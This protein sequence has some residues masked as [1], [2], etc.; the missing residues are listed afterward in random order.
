MEMIRRPGETTHP[1]PSLT[2]PVPPHLLST[3]YMAGAQDKQ[4][5]D[6]PRT[7]G[8]TQISGLVTCILQRGREDSSPPRPKKCINKQMKGNSPALVTLH[9]LSSH[10]W[11]V[12]AKT[13]N[14]LI[15]PGGPTGRHLLPRSHLIPS[16]GLAQ[17]SVKVFPG[18]LREQPKQTFWATQYF[19]VSTGN[20]WSFVLRPKGGGTASTQVN[21]RESDYLLVR[22]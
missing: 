1:E 10:V 4:S 13:E 21:K 18:H 5:E 22:L 14:R 8:E 3:N 19:Q 11:L 16:P 7:G 12:A 17:K 6:Q 15:A 2:Q 9:P 20:K